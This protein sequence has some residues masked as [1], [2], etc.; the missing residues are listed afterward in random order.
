MA[1]L[2]DYLDWRGD[3]SFEERPLNE[4]DSLIFCELSYI[5]MSDIV[6][7]PDSRDSVTLFDLSEAYSAMGRKQEDLFRNNPVPL[8]SAAAKSPRFRDL[9]LSRYINHIDS[10]SQVQFSAFCAQ[11]PGE[12]AYVAYR[13]T[14]NSVTGWREDFN[15]SFSEET[16]GQREA[17]DYLEQAAAVLPGDLYV[18]GH[19]KGGNLAIYAAAFCDPALRERIPRVFSHDGPGFMEKLALSEE[20]R[21]LL[22]RVE[23]YIPE[24]S[25]VGILLDNQGDRV[26]LKSSAMGVSQHDPMTWQVRGVSFEQVDSQSAASAVMDKALRTWLADLGPEQRRLFVDTLF[27]AMD[28]SGARTLSDLSADSYS[29]ILRTM[30]EMEPE[31]R[32]EI[33]SM[34][35][36][37]ASATHDAFWQE[38]K[39]S[40]VQR[41]EKAIARLR[42]QKEDH[43]KAMPAKSEE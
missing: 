7:G 16:E 8:L 13:G 27:D 37:L 4:V 6:P 14:D 18:G 19:S 30:F 22:P 26:I 33:F 21:S 29:A 10:E 12:K 34:L 25:V 5:D 28:Q 20:Y 35:K 2:L 11:L 41:F 38:S 36:K 15:F 39:A 23:L 32:S 9:R 43:V 42:R 31:R 3:L 1:N 24:T 40:M 17:V